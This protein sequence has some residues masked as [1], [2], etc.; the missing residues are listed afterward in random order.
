M[1]SENGMPSTHLI[2][3]VVKIQ[4]KFIRIEICNCHKLIP[5]L[6]VISWRLLESLVHWNLS[7]TYRYTFALFVFLSYLDGWIALY[8][9]GKIFCIDRS[10][11]DNPPTFSS[12][13]VT[14][15]ADIFFDVSDNKLLNDQCFCGWFKTPWYFHDVKC[16]RGTP[17]TFWGR[18]K[19]AI[20][21]QMTFSIGVSWMKMFKFR[22][23]FLWNLF[24]CVQ[25]T[26]FQ[27]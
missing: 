18:D 12:A 6:K 7:K 11:W 8:L 3:S 5:W 22:F 19:M 25:L 10:F 26:I 27:H 2:E 20:I 24:L 9:H 15:S 16:N 13:P 14:R 21:F 4:N 23:K 1:T 17:L